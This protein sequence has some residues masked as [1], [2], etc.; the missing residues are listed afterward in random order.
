MDT[1]KNHFNQLSPEEKVE[2]LQQ[3]LKIEREGHAEQLRLELGSQ[4]ERLRRELKEEAEIEKNKALEQLRDELKGEHHKKVQQ[5]MRTQVMQ[6]VV[7]LDEENIVANQNAYNV[8]YRYFYPK[9][10]VTDW[11]RVRTHHLMTLRILRWLIGKNMDLDT[12][13]SLF[14]SFFQK[15]EYFQ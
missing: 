10:L 8:G 2:I 5:V 9:H 4:E 14:Y 13:F 1:N 3:Q 7:A 11:Q 6:A 15:V 12:M